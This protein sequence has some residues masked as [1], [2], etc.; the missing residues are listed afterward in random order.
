MK[1]DA[2]S[3]RK[4]LIVLIIISLVV[5]FIK[6]KKEGFYDYN[7]NNFNS[8]FGKGSSNLLLANFYP[9]TNKK[10]LGDTEYKNIW[11]LFPHTKTKSF[12]QIT[13]NLKYLRNP[14][15]ANAIPAEFNGI[16]YKDI[17]N[18]SNIIYPL[19]PVENS[20]DKV[21]VGYFNTNIDFC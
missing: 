15:I 17:K 4:I 7:L 11:Y 20:P 21:R 5:I 3:V 16:F 18:K 6:N 12:N 2:L 14:D 10:V 19:P 8:P 13:N 9:L 1:I